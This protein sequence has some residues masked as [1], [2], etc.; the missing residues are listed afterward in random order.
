MPEEKDIVEVDLDRL[1]WEQIKE[2]ASN[3]DW[4]PDWIPEY[5]Y[6][7][8]WVHDVCEFLKKGK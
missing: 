5:Y 2:A 8:D 7:N 3:S 1:A 4:I 6:M